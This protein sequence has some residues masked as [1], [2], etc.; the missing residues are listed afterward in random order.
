[1]VIEVSKLRNQTI[2]SNK[3]ERKGVPVIDGSGIVSV[4]NAESNGVAV[5]GLFA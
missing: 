1:M 2:S 4:R 3:M 5:L